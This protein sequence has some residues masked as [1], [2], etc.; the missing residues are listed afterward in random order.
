MARSEA[1]IT[2][3]IWDDDD[4]LALSPGAQRMFMFLVS[5]RDIAHTGVIAL[6]ERRW[7]RRARGMT[8]EDVV[9]ALAELAAGR[10][11]VIDEDTEELLVRSL[12]R[13]DK[14]Y[15]QP[16]VLCSARD[17]LALVESR[18]LLAELAAE[19]RRIAAA[20]DIGERS[21]KIVAEMLEALGDPPP[22][23][24]ATLAG[25]LAEPLREPLPNPCGNPTGSTYGERGMVTEVSNASPSPESPS[26]SG[27][28]PL[29]ANGG[30]PPE[31]AEPP[32][33]DPP[34]PRERLLTGWLAPLGGKAHPHVVDAVGRHLDAAL[35]VD[36]PEAD[37]AEA[38]RLW[39]TRG[40]LG[41]GVLPS[42]IHQVTTAVP[43]T[44]SGDVVPLHQA[45][46]AD[47]RPST[48]DGRVAD[49]WALVAELEAE[50]AT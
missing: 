16:N 10:F 9:E 40:D 8:R 23:P 4:F 18:V 28:A 43:A 34:G 19:L 14:V 42:L 22:N 6:R 11:V 46:R 17:H 35:G 32:N 33:N 27:A 24:P 50:V 5:Q 36:I 48:K 26:P 44:T 21:A 13:R 25:T 41:P 2:V 37:I 39:Q 45:R 15:R 38:L 49:H 1:R 12:M 47:P 29:R 7:A 3:D 20:D 30:R 31:L